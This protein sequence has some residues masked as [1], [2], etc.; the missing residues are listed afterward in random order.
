VQWASD[1]NYIYDDN[2]NKNNKHDGKGKIDAYNR[3]AHIRDESN[4]SP[5][6]KAL[7]RIYSA[8]DGLHGH[9]NNRYVIRIVRGLIVFV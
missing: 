6:T 9:S 5:T 2:N 1:E 3:Y 4:A 8:D 7:S